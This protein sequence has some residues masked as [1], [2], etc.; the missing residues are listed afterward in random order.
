M[1]YY[2]EY[3][4]KPQNWT[5]GKKNPT[6]Q[7][8]KRAKNVNRRSSKEDAQ[9]SG[10]C[11]FTRTDVQHHS[12][13]GDANLNTRFYFTFARPGLHDWS[14]SCFK[15]LDIY[16]LLS[17]LVTEPEFG[18]GVF[19]LR[20]IVRLLHSTLVY[21]RGYIT[22][23]YIKVSSNPCI[24]CDWHKLELSEGRK[25]MDQVSS[26]LRTD[27]DLPVHCEWF[28]PWIG[29]PSY[30]KAAW[31]SHEE[32]ANNQCSFVVSESVPSSRFLPS[33]PVLTPSVIEHGLED[34][35][36]GKSFPPKVPLDAVLPQ[37]YKPN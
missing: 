29:G 12:H 8:K 11:V 33:I 13:Q 24:Y 37:Q 6:I 19:H 26:W 9:M 2:L 5:T 30:K 22:T 4:K 25:P 28:H 14:Q 34:V 7:F 3:V 21:K 32:Q 23:F 27:E 35:S 16:S 17:H 20:Q 1:N 18:C 36:W 10:N 31:A 15:G